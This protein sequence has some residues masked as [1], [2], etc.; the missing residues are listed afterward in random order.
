MNK[1]KVNAKLKSNS[2]KPQIA[3]SNDCYEGLFC[4][5]IELNF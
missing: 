3:H 2:K 4:L 5:I 1:L